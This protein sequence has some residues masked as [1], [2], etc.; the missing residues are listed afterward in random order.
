MFIKCIYIIYFEK[1][2]YGI[3]YVIF[4]KTWQKIAYNESIFVK[5]VF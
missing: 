2:K 5:Y 3:K 1:L 4:S